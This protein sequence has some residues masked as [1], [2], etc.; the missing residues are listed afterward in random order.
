MEPRVPA[1]RNLIVVWVTQE[2]DYPFSARAA[3]R[4]A[5]LGHKLQDAAVQPQTTCFWMSDCLSH[6]A[7]IKAIW[8]SLEANNSKNVSLNRGHTR[9]IAN[10][11]DVAVALDLSVARVARVLTPHDPPRGAIGE[12]IV[13][14]I[15]VQP[16]LTGH[17]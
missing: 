4:A 8:R 9:R 6:L 13:T 11:A 14:V 2:P 7:E 10:C 17:S 1:R 12:R 5:L 16:C 15:A 3:T